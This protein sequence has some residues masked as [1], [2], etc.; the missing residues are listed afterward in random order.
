MLNC[1]N[2]SL[3]MAKVL[4]LLL[5][6][7]FH[8]PGYGMGIPFWTPPPLPGTAELDEPEHFQAEGSNAQA[9]KQKHSVQTEPGAGVGPVLGQ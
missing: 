2:I 6:F 5:L 7:P 1:V 9:E 8:P 3:C 4:L